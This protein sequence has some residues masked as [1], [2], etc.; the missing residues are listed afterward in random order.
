MMLKGT[1]NDQLAQKRCKKILR[2][3]LRFLRKYLKVSKFYTK[4][5]LVPW[6]TEYLEKNLVPLDTFLRMVKLP[7]F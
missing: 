4:I 5:F 3:I 6:D 7:K 2:E 1:P